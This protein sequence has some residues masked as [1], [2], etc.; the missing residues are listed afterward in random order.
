MSYLIGTCCLRRR[1]LFLAKCFISLL[2]VLEQ[3][4]KGKKGKCYFESVGIEIIVDLLEF[5]VRN[6]IIPMIPLIVECVEVTKKISA[7]FN[8]KGRD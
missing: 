2:E 8:R 3:R 4:C 1:L 6:W 7:S 5:R